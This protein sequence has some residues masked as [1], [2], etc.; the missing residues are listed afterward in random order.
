[1]RNYLL[2]VFL[3]ITTFSFA[4]Q[5]EDLTIGLFWNERPK[6][7]QISIASGTYSIL[8]D[9]SSISF[10]KG[11][12]M[13]ISVY[14]NSVNLRSAEKS[15]GNFK[16]VRINEL[17][18]NSSVFIQS[19]K[20]K[21][22]QREYEDDFVITSS[23]NR[24]KILN[25]VELS[26]YV[27]GV[28]QWEAG[29]GRTLEYYKVQAIITRTYALRNIHK[30][31]SERFNLCDRVDS[32]V[33]KGKTKNSDILQAVRET[34]DLVLVDEKMHLISALFHSNS[35]GHTLNSEDVWSQ[36]VPYLRGVE[37]SFSI[38]QPHYNWSKVIPT[39]DWLSTFAYTLKID[40]A[41]SSNLQV[42][43][44]FCP[45]QRQVEF[46]PNQNITTTMVRNA[47]GLKSTH[48]CVTEKGENMVIT[49]K[50]FGHGVG[51][52]QEGAIKMAEEGIP[53]DKILFYYYKNVHLVKRS[54][55]DYLEAM[56]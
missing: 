37:D 18:Q 40:T 27:A 22:Y 2:I 39:E 35:G 56:D 6:S 25:R 42:I 13:V 50:G 54:T 9:G 26:N 4:Q 51:L 32:Q 16:N 43:R 10:S 38:N 19:L 45:A 20:P 3:G 49:G 29:S 36:T 5:R 53:F 48:F 12:K 24:L 8:A 14:G 17:D 46:L 44:D 21:L 31:E 55:M 33:Y 15:Y 47:F 23:E 41:D 28:I 34:R 1:M 30:Y 52:S 11:M 7:I